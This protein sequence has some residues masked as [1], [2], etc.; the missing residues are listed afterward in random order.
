MKKTQVIEF[1]KT[2]SQVAKV[3]GIHP[4]S[5]SQWGE[6]IPEK[7]ALRLAL[8]TQGKLPYDPSFYHLEL[9]Q[10]RLVKPQKTTPE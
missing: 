7:Q 2:P 1:F 9:A 4:A 10:N 8:L 6:V 3:L 5:V